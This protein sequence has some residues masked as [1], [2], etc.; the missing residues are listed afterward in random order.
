[1][2]CETNNAECYNLKDYANMTSGADTVR[3]YK[4]N[5]LLNQSTNPPDP[6]VYL[7]RIVLPSSGFFY[8]VTNSDS[9][10]LIQNYGAQI[11]AQAFYNND[12]K[13]AVYEDMFRTYKSA[14]IP[15]TT[16]I[17]YI[18]NQV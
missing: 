14:F 13:L 1:M 12:S 5:E 17:D 7:I 8:G 9:L 16:A 4:E 18:R 15:L 2:T 10:Y 11:V 3:I 6:G